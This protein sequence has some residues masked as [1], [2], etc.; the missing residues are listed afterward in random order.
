MVETQLPNRA[1]L[2][3]LKA[4]QILSAPTLQ[5]SYIQETAMNLYTLGFNVFPVPYGKKAGWP[6]RMLQYTRLNPEDIYPLF[7]DRCNLAVM[8]GRTSGNLFVVDCET[9]ATFEAHLQMLKEAHIPIFAVRS[10]GGRGGGHLYLRCSDGEVKGVKAGER[11]DYEVRGNRCY[12]LAPPSLHPTSRQLY[13]WYE[14]E[15]P[16]PPTISLEQIN[17]LALTLTKN[18]PKEPIIPQVFSELSSLTR[19]FITSG[20]PEGERNN[21][22]FTAACDLAGNDYDHHTAIQLLLPP[23]LKSGTPKREAHDT[24]HSAYSKPRS[25]AKPTVRKQKQPKA[26]EKA[27]FWAQEQIWQGREGQTDKAVFL[28]C[29]H[30]ATTANEKGVFRASCREIAEL[31]RVARQTAS[32]SL[33]RLVSAKALVFA[34]KNS[35]SAANLYRFVQLPRKPIFT[36]T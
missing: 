15:T 24:I 21:R 14:R 9:K 22:L 12:V 35:T 18:S 30:R 4:E 31:A 19:D 29:C 3:K 10:G 25:P 11:K 20:A 23:A 33:K 1:E 13:Q 27:T 16:E 7:R 2:N 8:T 5:L 6:W 17:F 28:A 32:K 26:Y 36:V 34:G